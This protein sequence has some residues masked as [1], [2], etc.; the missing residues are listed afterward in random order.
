MRTFISFTAH[1]SNFREFAHVAKLGQKLK[2]DKVWARPADSMGQGLV[3]QEEVLTPQ[4]TQELFTIMNRARQQFLRHWFS[5]TKISL[6][7]GLQFLVGG[8]RPY[9]CTAGS[10]LITIMPNGD[11]YPC[12]RLLLK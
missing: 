8:G 9:R 3:L 10:S 4:E 2:V 1:R 6:E 12:R 7:R 11:V 5:K